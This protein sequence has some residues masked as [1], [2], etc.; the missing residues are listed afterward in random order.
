[1]R[2]RNFTK[3]LVV[4]GFIAVSGLFGQK[5]GA[6][7]TGGNGNYTVTTGNDLNTV[8]TNSNYTQETMTVTFGNDLTLPSSSIDVSS[9][10]NPIKNLT[11]DLAGKKFYS[12][13]DT[14]SGVNI[15][16]KDGYNITVKNMNNDFSTVT[17]NTAP[18]DVPDSD[19]NSSIWT[20][21]YGN[22]NGLVYG[23]WADSDPVNSSLTFVNCNYDYSSIQGG[24][25][26]PFLAHRFNVYFSG[27]NS[28][29][30]GNS[31]GNQEYA[32]GAYF[33]VLDG[34]STLTYKKSNGSKAMMNG[35]YGA[36]RDDYIKI[37]TGATLNINLESKNAF[38]HDDAGL[39]EDASSFILENN[40][41]L[42]YTNPTANSGV[43]NTSQAK[44]QFNQ[45]NFTLGAGSVTK[46]NNAGPIFSYQFS[47][48]VLLSMAA[49]A[50]AEFNNTESENLWTG[51]PSSES[52][53]D[54]GAINS[55]IFSAPSA[56]LFTGEN[57]L[58]NLNSPL[59]ATGYSA[60][61]GSGN[62][63]VT[64]T[65]TTGSFKGDFTN[66]KPSSTTLSQNELSALKE[67]R[68]IVFGGRKDPELIVGA[69]NYVWNYSLKG[70][71]NTL[72]ARNGAG[73]N[74]MSFTVRDYQAGSGGWQ[75]MGK[76]DNKINYLQFF[77][78][79]QDK[80]IPINSNFSKVLSDTSG[81]VSKS[82]FDKS[83]P[84]TYSTDYVATFDASHG[85]L[86]T[87]VG[88]TKIKTYTGTVEWLLTE[89]IS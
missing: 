27:N 38:Y 10:S 80:I 54:L 21:Y 22:W 14:S 30:L 45:I 62:P 5:A 11:L 2:R 83:V 40:G 1:M 55:A 69:T 43:F 7:I 17:S 25:V 6:T 34:E 37:D 3:F 13:S 65:V 29:A 68:R 64:T 84:Q 46:F 74:Q 53:I 51:T 60:K 19:G 44:P 52:K 26:Q 23:D 8:L 31:D 58:I 16:R 28:F 59:M 85:L 72:L 35:L 70:R 81:S 86:V 36:D 88:G 87:P 24:N 76:I 82:S 56:P 57:L 33:E 66:T 89:P 63:N 20:K 15:G 61:D 41:T 12:R 39:L 9:S 77:F 71:M 73:D 47:N 32:E 4:A 75:I 67:S 18:Q 48:A 42:N 79:D 49:D 78:K 50:T